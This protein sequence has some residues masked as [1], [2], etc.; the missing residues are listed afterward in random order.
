MSRD[1]TV[2]G[3]GDGAGGGRPL[4]GLEPPGPDK[5]ATTCEVTAAEPGREFAFVT[6]RP[7]KPETA[8]RYVL[9]PA[10]DGATLVTESFQLVKPL[11][12]ISNFVTRVS[13]GVRD[14]RADLDEDVRLSL[15]RLKE[16]A[17][18]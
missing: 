18:A 11:G 15:A 10:G 5:W 16:I 7:A 12:A 13:T 17:E 8:W 1:N 2:A 9:Q 14:R 4:S 6:G 3:R